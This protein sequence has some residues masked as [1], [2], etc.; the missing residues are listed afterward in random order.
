MSYAS[1]LNYTKDVAETLS[2]DVLFVH[3][4]KDVLHELSTAPNSNTGIVFWSLPFISSGTFT[5]IGQQ[6]NEIVTINV[7]IY[8]QDQM[9]SEIDQNSPEITSEEIQVLSQTK[10][11]ADEFVRQF[12]FNSIS[13]STQEVSE[14]LEILSV[15]FDNL[16]KDND[17][18]LTGTFISMQVGVPDEFDY[19]NV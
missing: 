19:C 17:Y 14:E 5:E 7:L 16:I 13:S 3:G 2:T 11:I 9:G 12:N 1:L 8:K 10:D 4:R 18:L 15:S 6:F